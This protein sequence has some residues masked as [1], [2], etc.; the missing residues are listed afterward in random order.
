MIGPDA[1]LRIKSF[2][3]IKGG[4]LKT[5]S[6]GIPNSQPSSPLGSNRAAEALN[7]TKSLTSLYTFLIII[8]YL[9]QSIEKAWM[10][11]V[12]NPYHGPSLLTNL[13]IPLENLD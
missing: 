5:I 13:T 6:K 7:V 1:S 12:F 10:T 8:I 9:N 2:D 11:T 4:R 3:L